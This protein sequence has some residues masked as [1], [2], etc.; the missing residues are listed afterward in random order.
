[1]TERGLDAEKLGLLQR[2]AVGLQ[3]DERQEVAAAGRAILLLIEEI[4]RLHVVL[5]DL[6]LYPGTE[7][8]PPTEPPEATPSAADPEELPTSLRERIREG[9]LRPLRGRSSTAGDT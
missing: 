6:R 3:E 4:E 7:P 5:W 8:A 1:V 2:W 9:W